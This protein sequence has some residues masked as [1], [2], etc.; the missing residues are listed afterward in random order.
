MIPKAL[1][2]GQNGFVYYSLLWRRD[3]STWL[4]GVLGDLRLAFWY[5]N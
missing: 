2:R 5:P 1:G 4:G 3:T